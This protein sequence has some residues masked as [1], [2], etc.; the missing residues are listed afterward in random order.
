MTKRVLK[1]VNPVFIIGTSE[2]KDFTNLYPNDTFADCSES[3][4][5]SLI[6]LERNRPGSKL[7]KA[8]AKAQAWIKLLEEKRLSE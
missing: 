4:W 6:N 8:K 1:N 3:T 7:Q 5:Q 2:N